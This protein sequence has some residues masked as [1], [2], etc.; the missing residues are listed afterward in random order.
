MK[1][2]RYLGVAA[3]LAIAAW[4]AYAF[5]WRPLQCQK[6][7]QALVDQSYAANVTRS[8]RDLD[9]ARQNLAQLEP[10]FA[11]GCRSVHLLFTA[12]VNY[13]TIGRPEV[14]LG[15]YQDSLRYD[16]RPETYANI[17]DTQLVLGNRDA[18]YDNYL[19]ACS[20]HPQHLREIS[21]GVMRR[22]VRD[23]ILRR[24]PEQKQFIEYVESP[25]YAPLY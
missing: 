17:A 3:V 6:L 9:Q 11:L 12:A 18:A 23:E 16:Q 8:F 22:R 15:L 1:A 10:C 14:A 7:S 4:L 5:A 21:D 13:R 20:F 2:V 25:R 24:Y 19:K